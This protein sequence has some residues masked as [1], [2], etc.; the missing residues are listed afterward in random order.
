MKKKKGKGGLPPLYSCFKWKF[1]MNSFVVWPTSEVFV[2]KIWE[3]RGSREVSLSLLFVMVNWE[4][5]DV[6]PSFLFLFFSKG[7]KT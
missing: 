2:V 3:M 4:Y 5:M 6:V 7:S 1:R